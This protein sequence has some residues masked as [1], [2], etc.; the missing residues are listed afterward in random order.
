MSPCPCMI[1]S[2]P[3]LLTCV[4]FLF[5]KIQTLPSFP[6]SH[7]MLISRPRFSANF[8]SLTVSCPYSPFLDD[9]PASC[10]ALS[11]QR[12]VR[13]QGLYWKCIDASIDTLL[14]DYAHACLKRTLSAHN[15]DRASFSLLLVDERVLKI[16]LQD[17]A[18][19]SRQNQL[20]IQWF[21]TFSRMAWVSKHPSPLHHCH[22]RL[23]YFH[24]ERHHQSH[25]DRPSERDQR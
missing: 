2:T 11:R 1:R 7:E 21:F 14:A 9:F 3:F 17:Y 22:L 15:A 20:V 8:Y 19:F 18:S 5:L 6:F 12:S 23:R 10:T 13:L 16:H 25:W 24:C 4:F